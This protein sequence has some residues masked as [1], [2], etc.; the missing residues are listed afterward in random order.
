LVSY[1]KAYSLEFDVDCAENAERAIELLNEN[2]YQVIL[3]DLILPKNEM[4]FMSKEYGKINGIGVIQFCTQKGIHRSSKIIISSADN[5]LAQE[6]VE[7]YSMAIQLLVKPFEV[8]DLIERIE[9]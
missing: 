5:D 2:L 4:E 1:L 8:K 6:L 7:T 9:N 3:C